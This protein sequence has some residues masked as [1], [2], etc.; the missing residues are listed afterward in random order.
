MSAA[1]PAQ[2]TAGALARMGH[3]VV[4]AGH[5]L[6]AHHRVTRE[7]MLD[8]AAVRWRFLGLKRG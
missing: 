5:G 4:A 1:D 2:A 3:Q 7:D 8:R 6:S